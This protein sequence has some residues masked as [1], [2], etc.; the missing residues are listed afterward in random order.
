[1]Q[2]PWGSPLAAV[3]ALANVVLFAAYVGG[4]GPLVTSWVLAVAQ[5]LPLLVFAGLAHSLDSRTESPPVTR[6]LNRGSVL[7]VAF[8]L[9]QSLGAFWFRHHQASPDVNEPNTT[10]LLAPV[11][12][13][14]LAIA[15]LASAVVVWMIAKR[16]SAS[17]SSDREC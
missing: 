17:H 13:T 5:A 15:V 10:W 4:P 12:V 8:T 14:V 16:R 3:A 1:M 2:R 9:A 7:L 6:A 11:R